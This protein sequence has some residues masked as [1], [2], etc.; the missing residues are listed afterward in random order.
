M[1]T[2]LVAMIGNLGFPIAVTAYLLYRMEGSIKE[3]T[4]AVTAL[5]AS[6]SGGNTDGIK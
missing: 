5:V 6:Q 2:D 1:T 4:K 3:L